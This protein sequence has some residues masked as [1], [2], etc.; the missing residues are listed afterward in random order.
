MGRVGKYAMSKSSIAKLYIKE[1]LL[2]KDKKEIV[3]HLVEETGLHYRTIE[4]YYSEIKAELELI[5][6]IEV[7]KTMRRE[8]EFTHHKGRPRQFFIF[9]DKRLYNDLIKNKGE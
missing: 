9:D 7:K 1:N 2:K 8:K 5:I 3:E 6:D 4:V